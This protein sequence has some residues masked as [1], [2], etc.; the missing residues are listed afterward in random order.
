MARLVE[1]VATTLQSIVKE[2]TKQ[3]KGMFIGTLKDAPAF[4]LS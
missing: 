2:Q 1:W 3:T 4:F